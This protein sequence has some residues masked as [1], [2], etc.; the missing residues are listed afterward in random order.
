MLVETIKIVIFETPVVV[1]P[2]VMKMAL[3][4]LDD[5][6]LLVLVEVHLLFWP[7]NAQSTVLVFYVVMFF[8]LKRIWWLSFLFAMHIVSEERETWYGAKCVEII[9][10]RI[11]EEE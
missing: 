7:N 2:D 1:F 4:L 10:S 8:D 9:I 6:V 5:S 3:N 11:A